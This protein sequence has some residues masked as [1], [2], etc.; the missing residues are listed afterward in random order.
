[1][2]GYWILTAIAEVIAALKKNRDKLQKIAVSKPKEIDRIVLEFET[3]LGVANRLKKALVDKQA[4]EKA[5][6]KE[7][8][9]LERE[10]EKVDKE[11]ALLESTIVARKQ[12]LTIA[13][14]TIREL[15]MSLA[16]ATAQ[17]K[18]TQKRL[19]S[20]EAKIEENTIRDSARNEEI[21]SVRFDHE[22]I[23]ANLERERAAIRDQHE[24]L[25]SKYWALRFLIREQMLSSPEVKIVGALQGKKSS[26]LDEIK[27]ITFLTRY[28]VEQGVEQLAA[29]GFLRIS[30]EGEIKV[31]KPIAFES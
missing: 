8:T 16:D 19:E 3:V 2:A 6:N 29:R 7:I 15:E 11:K 4:K 24:E 26:T 5:V 21:Q 12:D 13:E 23:M 31:L 22:D 14:K 25:N 9:G 10:L 20:V 1:L 28:R 18:K 27:N 17:L 30:S